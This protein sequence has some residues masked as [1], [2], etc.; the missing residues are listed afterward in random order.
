MIAQRKI[1]E[2]LMKHRNQKVRNRVIANALDIPISTVKN[3]LAELARYNLVQVEIPSEYGFSGG[4][5]WWLHEYQGPPKLY[6]IPKDTQHNSSND[7]KGNIPMVK[8]LPNVVLDENKRSQVMSPSDG[9]HQAEQTLKQLLTMVQGLQQSF[10]V[11]D[12]RM[13][14]I[15]QAKPVPA[16]TPPSIPPSQPRTEPQKKG[17]DLAIHELKTSLVEFLREENLILLAGVDYQIGK[18][19]QLGAVDT[20]YIYVKE[21]VGDAILACVGDSW[22]GY[23]VCYRIMS[24]SPKPATTAKPSESHPSNVT[25]AKSSKTAQKAK[26]PKPKASAPPSPKRRD[27]QKYPRQPPPPPRGKNSK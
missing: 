12:K 27:T 23:P 10:E 18:G 20:I 16:P 1:F 3:C 6:T 25:P 9:N 2:Y 7:S 26:P 13:A 15:E 22:S 14:K 11:L 17:V 21:G 19:Q 24:G 8:V 4:L 5:P